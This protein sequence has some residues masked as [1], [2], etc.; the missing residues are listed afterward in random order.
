M[1]VIPSLN[2]LERV[3]ALLAAMQATGLSTPGIVILGADQANDIATLDLPPNWKAFARSSDQVSLVE[4]LNETFTALPDLVWYGLLTDD[5]LPVTPG[6]DTA[7]I[8][9]AREIGIASCDDGWQSPRRMGNAVVW[10]GDILRA[11]GFW[12]PPCV[13][14][15]YV[16]DFWETIGR[17]FNFWR[18]LMEV[19]V[20]HRH[21]GR[22]PDVARDATYALGE[23]SMKDDLE[24]FLTWT[25]SEDHSAIV[26]RFSAVALAAAPEQ[27][28]RLA[29]ARTRSVFIATPIARHPVRHFTS[30]LVRTI[31]LLGSL[32]IRSYVQNVVGSSNLP[33]ARNEL[34]AAFLATDFTDMLFVDDDMGWD[35]KDLVRLLASD[36]PLIGGAGAKK[37]DLPD[38]NPAK[39]CFASEEGDLVQDE[40][41]AMRIRRIG[42]GFVKIERRVFEELALR[43]PEW[44]RNGWPDMPEAARRWYYR[45]FM[46]PDD[47]DD[48]GEDFY[49]CNAWRAMGGEVWLDPTIRLTHVGEK[50]YGGDLTALLERAPDEKL[51]EPAMPA[52]T[53]LRRAFDGCPLCCKHQSQ[54]VMTATAAEH[55]LYRRSLPA[56]MVWHECASCGHLFTAGYFEGDAAV[57]LLGA[58]NS[59]QRFGVDA[60]GDRPRTVRIVEAVARAG[61]P[62]GDWLDIGFGNGSLLMAAQE[63]GWRPVGV[64]ARPLNVQ[65]AVAF[66]ID[67]YASIAE[68]GAG[69]AVV[70]LADVLEHIPFPKAMLQQV[71]GLLRPDGVLFLSTPNADSPAWRFATEAKA[72]PYWSEIEHYHSFGRKRL[73]AL[74]EECGFRAVHFAISE[75][76]RMGM[77]MIATVRT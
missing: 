7:L 34:V 11:A 51:P 65:G 53:F 75:R 33:R 26:Q 35:P 16:D 22:C 41:G 66:G 24:A 71:R 10:R 32:G 74:L 21:W 47:A 19:R 55:P 59:I 3:K 57:A 44:K 54:V 5:S 6:W 63:F 31:A 48:T 14:H 27:A 28:D 61:A 9:G 4:C 46:F 29:R 77:E 64:E 62:A 45:F 72:N 76:Y 70:S 18:C 42:T 23:S 73:E 13:R 58:A 2:R 43:H 60:E 68:V 15:N 38:D 12:M 8:A 49:F 36:K 1:W 37:V 50:E 25:K 20:E 39:W 69:Y 52:P 17:R 30:S 56:E 67:A 40:M